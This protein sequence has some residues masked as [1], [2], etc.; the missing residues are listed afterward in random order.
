M[1]G[2]F[3]SLAAVMLTYLAIA[4]VLAQVALAVFL[5]QS[6]K[7]D[8]NRL[9]Q[10]LAIA[11]GVDLFALRDQL[12]AERDDLLPEQVSYDEILQQRAVHVRNLEFREES[13]ANSLSDLDFRQRDFVEETRRLRQVR[14]GF[15]TELAEVREGLAAERRDEIRT[16][17]MRMRPRQAKE[18]VIL[19]LEEGELDE[20]VL[21]FAEMPDVARARIA[22]EFRTPEEAEQLGEVLRRLREGLPEAELV[23]GA[24]EALER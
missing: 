22:A 1:I 13:L 2:R 21:L 18:Q 23:D 19:M 9:I 8:G 14:T 3:A 10:M 4:T 12:E 6:W 7:L 5:W 24:R 15:E 11:Q 16:W 20:V 17:L